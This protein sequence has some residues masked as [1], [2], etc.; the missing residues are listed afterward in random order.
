ME[1]KVIKMNGLVAILMTLVTCVLT[2]IFL[3]IGL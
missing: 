1:S 2:F 3:T